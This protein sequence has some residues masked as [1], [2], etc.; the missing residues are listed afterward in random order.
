MRCSA[1]CGFLRPNWQAFGAR[2]WIWR[3]QSPTFKSRFE[4]AGTP[5]DTNQ[6]ALLALLSRESQVQ[7]KCEKLVQALTNLEV[8]VDAATTA[9]AFSSLRQGVAAKQ[10]ALKVAKRR[11][12][13]HAPW[14]EYFGRLRKRLTTQQDNTVSDFVN[15]YGP[16]TSVIQKRL[17]SI[18]GFDDI[19]IHSHESAIRVRVRRRG[20]ELRPTDYFSQSQQQTL[21]VGFISYD[22]YLPDVVHVVY[23]VPG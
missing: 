22:L 3:Q 9:A 2:L 13:Q 14:L 23:R 17:R 6:D 15:D 21:A 4:E 10:R 11:S 1:R 20:E 5:T 19:E 12:D 7:T 18:Y 16:R 8:S